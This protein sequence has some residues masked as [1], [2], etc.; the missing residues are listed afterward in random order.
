MLELN[1]V[2]V[3]NREEW[4]QHMIRGRMMLGGAS[5]NFVC[6]LSSRV[7][8][9]SQIGVPVFFNSAILYDIFFCHGA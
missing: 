1:H 6:L 8:S 2:Q 9:G 5:R 7:F 4:L 3:F